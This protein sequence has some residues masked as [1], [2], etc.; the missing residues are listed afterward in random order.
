MKIA[1]GVILVI[2]L[3]LASALVM[4]LIFGGPSQPPA[5]AGINEP[6]K[7]LDYSG[8][9]ELDRYQAR[10]GSQLAYRHYPAETRDDASNGSVVLLHGSSADSR[11]LHPL[12][13]AYAEAGFNA[14]ALDV[15]GHGDS[16]PRGD[17]AYIGQLEDDLEDFV[18]AVNPDTPRT[19]TG[20]SAGGG[21]ALRIAGSER[22][23]LFAHY[24]LLSPFIS[25]EA[26]THRPDTGGWTQVGIP[27]YISIALLNQL[28]ISAFN[29][30]PV[31]R[32]ALAED[33][34][35]LLTPAYSFRLAQN[36]RPRADYRATIQ[37]IDHPTRLIAGRDDQ[38]LDPTHFETVFQH[39]SRNVP[40]TLL[41]GI[42]HVG[43]V[44]E[45]D[46]LQAIITET[47]HL[48]DTGPA[49]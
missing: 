46:A 11:S 41:S 20:F 6:F 43:L 13:T 36:Y 14:Y 23:D 26:P 44:V 24:L 47:R 22:S 27:R 8:L 30:L 21:F 48:L 45:S 9:P 34:R 10:D 29:H 38:V 37:A 40:V 19:L 1:A 28:G 33:A 49:E 25:Q 7:N 16:G 3:V 32:F 17:I 18:D 12:A 42:G 31:V 5:M 4:A 35:G 39:A 2:G 15:R